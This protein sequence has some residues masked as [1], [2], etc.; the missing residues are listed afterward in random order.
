MKLASFSVWEGAR[1]MMERGLLWG[2]PGGARVREVI[3]RVTD[4][5]H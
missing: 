1:A 4:S 2:G 5:D 3:E